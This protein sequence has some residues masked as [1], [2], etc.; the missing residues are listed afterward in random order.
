VQEDLMRDKLLG[1][2]ES[3][4]TITE[5]AAEAADAKATAGSD[6]KPKA[7]KSSS[8]KAATADA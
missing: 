8:K 3:H 6:A 1:W 4:A 5:T 7:K 2:L